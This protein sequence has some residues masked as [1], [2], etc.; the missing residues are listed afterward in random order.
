M[1]N[2]FEN[3]PDF[4]ADPNYGVDIFDQEYSLDGLSLD[5]ADVA[6]DYFDPT[7]GLEYPMFSPEWWETY[8][9]EWLEKLLENARSS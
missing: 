4:R 2:G 3:E 1:P 6:E 5:P 7:A 8:G 9:D